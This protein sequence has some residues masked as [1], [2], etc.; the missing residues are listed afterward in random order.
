MV[1]HLFRGLWDFHSLCFPCLDSPQKIL[2]KKKPFCLWREKLLPSHAPAPAPTPV[3]LLF[4]H[5]P[6]SSFP[7]PCS[8]FHSL[9]LLLLLSFSWCLSFS[10]FFCFLLSILPCFFL[11]FSCWSFS[12]LS[13][14]FLYLCPFPVYSWSV[15]S[16]SPFPAF[17]SLNFSPFY[18]PP[19][20]PPFPSCLSGGG[21]IERGLATPL[22]RGCQ[23]P[24][25]SPRPP[26]K[27]QGRG[28]DV[29]GHPLTRTWMSHLCDST[30]A[31]P[32]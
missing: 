21:A 26:T 13:L 16:P 12:F 22:W 1:Y 17:L 19:P 20:R 25:V 28:N 8:L 24:F 30:V 18:V 2:E 31:S 15:L 10:F 4:F 3:L 29:C 27:H 6:P 11:S 32:A 23:T 9:L 5:L 14:L 7:F